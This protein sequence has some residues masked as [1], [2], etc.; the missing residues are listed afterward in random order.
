MENLYTFDPLYQRLLGMDI[1]G[2]DIA[3]MK[4]RGLKNAESRWPTS[5]ISR[6]S[7]HCDGRSQG[8]GSV[9]CQPAVRGRGKRRDRGHRG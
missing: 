9:H 4:V 8:A 3:G 5:W 7:R 2:M 1:N 6:Q